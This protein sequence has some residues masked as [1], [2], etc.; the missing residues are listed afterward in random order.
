V[1]LSSSDY[2]DWLHFVAFFSIFIAIHVPI[3]GHELSLWITA[4]LV[5]V[6]V[7]Q[8]ANNGLT[9]RNLPEVGVNCWDRALIGGKLA[10]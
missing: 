9:I 6:I 5:F 8:M 3:S 7:K 10:A 2:D 4:P 1:A